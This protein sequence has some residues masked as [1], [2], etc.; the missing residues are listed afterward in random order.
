M[1]EKGKKRERFFNVQNGYRIIRSKKS[2][3]VALAKNS[4]TL[5]QIIFR[6]KIPEKAEEYAQKLDTE[7]SDE[8][9]TMVDFIKRCL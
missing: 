5:N 2:R 3:L 9:K 8:E 6:N 7:L 4:I 1:I